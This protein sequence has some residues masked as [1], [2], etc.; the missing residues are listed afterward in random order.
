M[1]FK[2]R[3]RRLTPRHQQ[4]S[5]SSALG[6][7]LVLMAMLAGPTQVA[8]P[9]YAQVDWGTAVQISNTEEKSWFPDV[10]VDVTGRVHTVWASSNHGYDTV[11]YR[12]MD[13]SGLWGP[14]PD[15]FAQDVKARLL[16]E[17]TRPTLA[18]DAS[19]TLHMTN[20]ELD[21]LYS[22]V[23]AANASE[24]TAWSHTKVLSENSVNY[25]SRVAIDSQGVVHVVYSDRVQGQ[26]CE[27]CLHL[28]HRRSEDG[29]NTW[30]VA[31]EVSGLDSGA[32]KPQLAIDKSDNLHVIWEAGI[33]GTLGQVFSPVRVYYSTS[34][35][36]GRTWSDAF[37][38]GGGQKG[39]DNF[40]A[41]K[42]AISVDVNDH[43]IAIWHSLP[44][45]RVYYQIS[46]DK[47][48]SWSDATLIPGMWGSWHVATMG[49]DS[50]S[51]AKDSAGQIHLVMVGRT[52]EEDRT[53]ALYHLVWNGTSW[54]SPDVVFRSSTRTPQWP[55]IAIGL[56]NQLHVVW[57]MASVDKGDQFDS[58]ANIYQIW[59][60]KSVSQAPAA[61]PVTYPAPTPLPVPTATPA[62]FDPTP[63]PVTVNSKFTPM[64]MSSIVG[65]S[66]SM[67]IIG[68]AILPV[69]AIVLAAFLLRRRR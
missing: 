28:F 35:N 60:A 52:A 13:P 31:V 27:T 55:R 5:V 66:Q 25:F 12:S 64:S 9:A 7:G 3:D 53:L 36:S 49:L 26:S 67:G 40:E 59:Y 11:M 37:E 50:Y 68:L 61:A 33:G 48:K 1:Q 39:Q 22:H 8:L 18:V 20:R 17:A 62:I 42:P 56:G 45:D 69:L 10:A 46:S 63:T 2:N 41:K 58:V 15:V 19:G 51:T 43:V 29:G 38:L 21:V 44:D 65:E 54:S 47:G 16:Q 24:V 30:S 57:Y 34:S 4:A 6:L 32:A 23:P 14:T